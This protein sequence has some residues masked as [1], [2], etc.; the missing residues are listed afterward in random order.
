MTIARTVAEVLE[1]HVTLEIEGIQRMY[2]NLYVPILQCPRGGRLLWSKHR[3]HRFASSALMAPMTVEFV[4]S[5]KRFAKVEGIDI[6][7]F[8]KRQREDDV[9]REYLEKFPGEEG[10][11]SSGRPRRR[12]A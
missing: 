8:K 11:S 5:I 4:R 9:A 12:L 3:G 2:L 1:D 10:V 7:S 6:V